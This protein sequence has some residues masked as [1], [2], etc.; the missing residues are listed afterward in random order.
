M[1]YLVH[2]GSGTMSSYAANPLIALHCFF[3]G[4]SVHRISFSETPWVFQCPASWSAEI[5][6]DW[7]GSG[8]GFSDVYARPTYQNTAVSAYLSKS[9]TFPPSSYYKSG[10]RATPDV[11]IYASSFPVIIAGALNFIGG[12]SLSSPLWG[13]VVSLINEISTKY[14]GK[15]VGFVNPLLY[16]MWSSDPTTFIDI[17]SGNNAGC[18]SSPC[19]QTCT[20]FYA[21]SGYD[22]VTGL[23]SPNWSGQQHST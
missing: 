6:I 4:H 5:A 17:T 1:T 20:G 12:T 19:A 21:T 14:T 9:I 13:G 22:A 23:G 16:T 15:T 18:P 3:C 10:N 2:D 11:S 7:F 8:G